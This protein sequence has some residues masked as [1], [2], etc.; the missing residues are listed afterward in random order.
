MDTPFKRARSSAASGWVATNL[1]ASCEEGRWVDN[2]V[3]IQFMPA[4]CSGWRDQFSCPLKLLKEHMQEPHAQRVDGVGDENVRELQALLRSMPHALILKHA[5]LTEEIIIE[6]DALNVI[7]AYKDDHPYIGESHRISTLH[8][9]HFHPLIMPSLLP[10]H[11]F[12]SPELFVVM[13]G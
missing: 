9:L 2:F 13:M 4:S 8:I 11:T 3:K 1:R 7:S 6:G 12:F 10:I 5:R